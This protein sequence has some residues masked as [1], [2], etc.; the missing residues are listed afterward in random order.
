MLEFFYS[1]SDI[2]DI[3]E[4]Y[5]LELQEYANNL[6]DKR[7]DLEHIINEDVE[8][9]SEYLCDALLEENN[10]FDAMGENDLINYEKWLG[11]GFF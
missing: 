8:D 2:V 5:C 4:K 6:D 7:Q 9:V 11:D 3:L 10:I 1:G